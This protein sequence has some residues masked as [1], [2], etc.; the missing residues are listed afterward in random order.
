MF[1]GG[2]GFASLTV[3][4]SSCCTRRVPTPDA[5]RRAAVISAGAFRGAVCGP[6]GRHIS[7]RDREARAWIKPL[8][9]LVGGKGLGACSSSRSIGHRAAFWRLRCRR[10]DAPLLMKRSVIS[11]GA[12][13]IVDARDREPL[14]RAMDDAGRPFDGYAVCVVVTPPDPDATHVVTSRQAR[15]GRRRAA[16]WRLRRLSCCS[17]ARSS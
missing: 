5:T 14:R 15:D 12:F 11:A 2:F 13:V 3:T 16:R 7:L 8:D 9:A 10:S 4:N 17:A 1:R 6:L